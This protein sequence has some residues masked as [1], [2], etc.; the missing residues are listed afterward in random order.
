MKSI[1]HVIR[2][3]I[4]A[5]L[6]LIARK[7]GRDT[8]HFN[9]LDRIVDAAPSPQTLLDIFEGEWF[10]RLPAPYDTLSAGGMNLFNDD[11]IQWFFDVIG[12]EHVREARALDLGPLEGGHSYM[13]EKFGAAEVVGVE[14]NTRA[15]LKCLIVKE[16]L[17]M[18]R[19]RFLC[20]NCVEYLRGGPAPFDVCIASGILYHLRNPAEFIALLSERCRGYVYFWT[21][22]YDRDVMKANPNIPHRFAGSSAGDYQGFTHTLYH[23][24]YRETLHSNVFIGGVESTSN[25]MSRDDILR[26]LEHFHFEVLRVDDQP[27]SALGPCISIV[28]Q[29]A[30]S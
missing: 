13:L 18:S 15:F 9:I 14:A 30:A 25:W 28:A 8:A 4:H 10:S 7:T 11:R 12:H 17:G 20:G 3:R 1:K 19:V 2:P 16:I 27:E 22:Y 6:S 23:Q 29:R 26:C 5:L 24:E 21:N